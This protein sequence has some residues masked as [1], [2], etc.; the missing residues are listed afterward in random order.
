MISGNVRK[1]KVKGE[2]MFNVRTGPSRWFL[3]F[4]TVA[5]SPKISSPPH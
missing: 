4:P 5:V 2:K 1:E 3:H